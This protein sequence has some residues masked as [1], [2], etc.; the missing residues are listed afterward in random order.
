MNLIHSV[1][2]SLIQA[3][4]E[5][6]PVSSSGHL[7]FFKGILGLQEMPL[8][9]DI[10]LHCGSLAA[11][12]FF[13][14]RELASLLSGAWTETAS[15]QKT[16]P[17]SR[18]LLYVLISTA[19]TFCVYLLFR[20]LFDKWAQSPSVLPVTFLVTTLML[21]ST[22][23]R[24]T[25]S[26]RPVSGHSLFLPLVAGVFQGV[27][28]LPGV[29]RSGAS[30]SSLLVLGTERREAAFYAFIL[31]IPAILGALAFKLTGAIEM[32][33]FMAHWGTLLLCF[34]VSSV[35]S[36]LFLSLLRAVLRSGK[37]WLFSFYTLALA[38]LSFILLR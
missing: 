8:I 28:I 31:A 6:L 14:R 24:K 7:L 29:S 27:A 20:K 15:R 18:F 17:N 34:A 19:V 12:V 23:A 38:V 32:D 2:L 35:F 36:F 10:V 37:F 33:F 21:L 30:I 5:F 11:I 4:T 22:R 25:Q 3:A 16:R 1:I 9:F 13:Y 26:E